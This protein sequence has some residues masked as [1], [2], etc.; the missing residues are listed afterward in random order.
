MGHNC[1]SFIAIVA[2][3]LFLVGKITMAE[4]ASDESLIT[5]AHKK[6][7]NFG[8]DEERKAFENLIQ[9][10]QDGEKAD[11]TPELKT[12]ADPLDRKI[13]T[14][15][16]YAGLWEKDRVIKAEWLE[17]L[18]I[19]PKASAKVT[20]SR[21][22]E[23]AGA[24]L[25]G[26]VDL[27]WAKIQFPLRAFKCAFTDDII[28]DRATIGSLQFQSTFIQNLNAD[29][30]TV[31]RDISFVDG[32]RAVGQVWLR[33]AT[34]NGTL[35]CDN[36][37]FI[38]PDKIALNLEAAKTGS[39]FMRNGFRAEGQVN[40]YAAV[41]SGTLECDNG[42]FSNPGATALDLEAATS[43]QVLLWN[44]FA[45]DGKVSLIYATISNV[46][47]CDNGHFIN[48]GK[49][50]LDFEGAKNGSVFMRD[51]FVAN[52][53]VKFYTAVISGTLQCDGG[54]FINPGATALN[55]EA[56]TSGQV[57]LW[58]EFAAD[59]EVNLSYATIS[60]TV[61]CG[62]GHFINPGKIALNFE[63][64]KIGSVYMDN[65][66]RAEGEVRLA[67]AVVDGDVVCDGSRFINPG[68]T[69][70][71]LESAKT[72]SVLL[73]NGFRAEGKVDLLNAVLGGNLECSR[74]QFKNAP[75]WAIN[76]TSA[77]IQD[78]VLLDDY[79]EAEGQVCFQNSEI[80]QILQV[81][82]AVWGKSASFDLRSA[83]VKTLLNDRTGWPRQDRLL[84][85]GFTYDLLHAE[86]GL[87]ART[88]IDWIQR[89]ARDQFFSQP[90]EQAAAVLRNMGL[91]EEAIKVM[92]AKNE[93]HGRYPHGFEEVIWYKVFG[94]FMGYGYRP[95]RAFYCSL[96]VVA[97][98][99]LIFKIAFLGEVMIPADESAYEATSGWTHQLRKT[100]PKFNAL[101]YSLETFVPLV[102]LGMQAHWTPN[103]NARGKFHLGKARFP[104]HG[105]VFRCYLWLHVLAGWVLTTLW[106]GGFTGLIKS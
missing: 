76:A 75:E 63:G 1:R 19:D 39:V 98:G 31:E 28:L 3:A 104:V 57:L 46:V 21:G 41:I 86:A 22:I 26:K 58:D 101:I 42:H 13:L 92:I 53:E 33:Y 102:T 94:P 74:G 81:I 105:G 47:D 45:A 29:H 82:N 9:K 65:S 67:N 90:Y 36:S 70:L 30:L 17:W 79:F 10:T 83:K 35:A 72:D 69:A 16:V 93:D 27:A 91:Q 2:S 54:R 56:A 60:N 99:Y 95:W 40:L 103:A 44:D 66:F 6:F 68:A 73:R 88:Q 14:D 8:S 38:N 78:N 97:I 62:N 34:I 87:N 4:T 15:P 77:H 71:N 64:A 106:V 23:I 80:G 55:L 85:H 52:G 7:T 32:C 5:L 96:L 18:C 24:R 20:T 12:V 37:S 49:I 11:L 89:Q 43:G 84:L 59:G 61:S 100:Y 48:P 50:A 25:E 51:G